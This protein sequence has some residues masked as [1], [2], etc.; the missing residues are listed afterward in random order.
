MSHLYAP[1]CMYSPSHVGVLLPHDRSTINGPPLA[2]IQCTTHTAKRATGFCSR[3]SGPLQAL[4]VRMYLNHAHGPME[5]C[6]RA[7][8]VILQSLWSLS[9]VKHGS[10]LFA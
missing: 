8:S 5:A 9:T 4:L 3:Q 10:F 7:A 6:S 1:I 2:T